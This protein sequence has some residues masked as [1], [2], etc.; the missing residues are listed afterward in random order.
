MTD[1]TRRLTKV[2]SLVYDLDHRRVIFAYEKGLESLL[3]PYLVIKEVQ[4]ITQLLEKVGK[5][6]HAEERKLRAME[7]EAIKS[8][9]ASKCS[10]RHL[11]IN[12]MFSCCKSFVSIKVQDGLSRNS[13]LKE[14]VLN[15]LLDSTFTLAR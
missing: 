9:L 1:Y 3:F 8:C 6:I 7:H 13:L 4:S 15:P 5:F 14:D 11:E 10:F 2:L 12:K